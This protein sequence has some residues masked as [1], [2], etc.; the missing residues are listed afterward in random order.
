M[1]CFPAAGPHATILRFVPKNHPPNQHAGRTNFR[2]SNN[3]FVTTTTGTVL[4]ALLLADL[5]DYLALSQTVLVAISP[6]HS[7]SSAGTGQSAAIVPL[8]YTSR[9]TTAGGRCFCCAVRSSLLVIAFPEQP[10]GTGDGGLGLAEQSEFVL[11]PRRQCELPP[12]HVRACKPQPTPRP[13]A[14]APRVCLSLRAVISRSL[15]VPACR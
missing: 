6:Q 7:D 14:A 10:L 8:R 13:L 11:L 2:P 3:S 15:P 1:L 5:H 9:Y 4:H 12:S